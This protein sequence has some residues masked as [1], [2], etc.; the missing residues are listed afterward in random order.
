MTAQQAE[1]VIHSLAVPETLDASPIGTL[2][3]GLEAHK[4]HL[5]RGCRL[6]CFSLQHNKVSYTDEHE[7]SPAAAFQNATSA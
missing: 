7:A 2:C 5:H 1:C 3:M 4:A 6:L